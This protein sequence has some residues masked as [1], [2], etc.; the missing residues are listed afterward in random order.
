MP[1]G[2]SF[3][4]C[5]PAVGRFTFANFPPLACT[6]HTRGGTYSSGVCSSS[7]TVDD[8]VVDEDDDEKFNGKDDDGATTLLL[9]G[10]RRDDLAATSTLKALD[11]VLDRARLNPLMNLLP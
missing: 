4:V 2:S 5:A 6:F 1:I 7:S 8:C 11:T 3:W 9:D 10:R